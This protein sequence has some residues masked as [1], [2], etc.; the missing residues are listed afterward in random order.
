MVAAD[1]PPDSET[2]HQPGLEP[3]PLPSGLRL[4]VVA[5]PDRG[6]ALPLGPGR[7]VCGKSSSSDL[8]L[9]DPL[10]SR[11]HL[12]ITVDARAVQLR[13]LGSRN[14]TFFNGAR[15]ESLVLPAGASVMVGQTELRLVG[16]QG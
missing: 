3:A 11:R 6:Q 7:Y 5:G 10:V 15:F 14:G 4:L 8:P 9:T 2:G 16:E 12:E 1:S 13:D